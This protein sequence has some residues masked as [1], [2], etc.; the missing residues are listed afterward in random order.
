[1]KLVMTIFRLRWK[2]WHIQIPISSGEEINSLA[3]GKQQRKNYNSYG[4][5]PMR[6][7]HFSYSAPPNFND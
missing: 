5:S 4:H 1:M 6:P 2:I 3:Y 7:N